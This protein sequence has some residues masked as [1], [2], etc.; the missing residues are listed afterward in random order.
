VGGLGR[1]CPGGL[2]GVSIDEVPG[3]SED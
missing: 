3:R 1:F 2:F